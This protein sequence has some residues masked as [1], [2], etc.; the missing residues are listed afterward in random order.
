MKKLCRNCLSQNILVS[1][2]GMLAPFFQKRVYDFYPLS[3]E[4]GLNL[5]INHSRNK[6]KKIL[7]NLFLSILRKIGVGQKLLSLRS[8]VTVKIRVCKNCGFVG[9]ECCYTYEMLKPLYQDYRSENY[10]AERSFFEPSY[11]KIKQYVGKSQEEISVRLNNLDQIINQY[12]DTH[13]VHQV[14]DWGG[15]EGK[16]VPTALQNKKVW[17]LDVSN[18]PV[19]NDQFCRVGQ[20]PP[21]IKFD[22]A[23]VAHVLEHVAAPYEFM[24][25][26]LM[27][28]N[29][30][31]YVYI[32]VPQDRTNED[33]Q[34]FMAADPSVCH[35]IHEHLN[36]FNLKSLSTLA[37]SLGIRSLYIEEKTM[38]VGWTQIKIVS[39]LF[40]KTT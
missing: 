40:S 10:D 3:L 24:L 39:G 11:E 7:G 33:I 9:P 23:Q 4:E 34:K 38:D 2:Q 22:Y 15:G 28:V 26:I 21:N 5:R 30:G 27:H 18:E 37:D 19:I 31:G 16:F 20:V 13:Q 35:V 25:N 29:T 8:S 12:M 1:T 32:E 36:L 14:I 17:I 6:F